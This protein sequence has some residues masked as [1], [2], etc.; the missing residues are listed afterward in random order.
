VKPRLKSHDIAMTNEPVCR[1]AGPKESLGFSLIEL[2][3][4]ITVLAV[5]SA[6]ALPSFRSLMRRNNVATQVNGLLADLQF[7]R[8]E[9]IS[10]RS[11]VSLC[12]RGLTATAADKTCGSSSKTFDTGWLVYTATASGTVFDSTKVGQEL[13]HVAAPPDT[14][15][16]HADSAVIPTFNARGEL[17]GGLDR[18]FLI[19]SKPSPGQVEVGESTTAIP[20]KRITMAASGRASASNLG[21]G[22]SCE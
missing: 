3:V 9:A 7:A 14:V 13:L 10:T 18:I 17:V 19:C 20:G 12:P 2:M 1:V 21:V 4:T 22:D 5:L 15:S 16:I 8:S 11:L 6:I